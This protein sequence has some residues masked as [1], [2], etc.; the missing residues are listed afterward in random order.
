RSIGSAQRPH[1]LQLLAISVVTAG[2]AL[3]ALLLAATALVVVAP[4]EFNSPAPGGPILR[5]LLAIGP[6]LVAA[7]VVAAVGAAVHAAAAR[8]VGRAGRDSL[9]ALRD[10]PRALAAAG[11]PAAAQVVALVVTRVAFAMLGVVLAR[12]LWAPIGSRLDGAG[13]D[14]AT[15]LLLVGFVA[16]WLCIVLAGGALHAWG[17]ATW[18]LLLDARAQRS[19]LDRHQEHPIGR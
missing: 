5:T 19:E 16:I 10:A 15:G 14:V 9:A 11:S 8:L 18:T 3:A 6:F 1:A 2:P 12:V 17:S 7:A 4:A 13:F